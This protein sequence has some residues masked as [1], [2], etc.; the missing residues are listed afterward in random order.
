[1]SVCFDPSGIPVPCTGWT[2]YDS[3]VTDPWYQKYLTIAWTG[4]F[5]VAFVLTLPAIAMAIPRRR[6]LADWLGLLGVYEDATRQGYDPATKR[7]EMGKPQRLT[8]TARKPFIAISALLRA[9]TRL[10]F[11][12]QYSSLSLG[13]VLLALLI[14]TIVLA[15]LLPESQ[16]AE[17]PNR[18]GFLAL[19][20]I[21]PLFVLSSKNGAIGLLLGR[22][23]T[24]VNFLH[25]W[26]GRAV[27]LLVV[28]HFALWTV[29]WS[30]AGELSEF[31]S[32]S[33]ERRGLG[34]FAFLLLITISSLPPFRRFSYPIFFTLHYVSIIGFLVFLNMHTIYARGWATWSVVAIY[35]IDIAGRVASVRVRWVQLEALE[36]GMTRLEMNGVSGG[37]SGG[38]TLD[39]RV[40][41]VPPVSPVEERKARFSR[42][43]VHGYRSLQAAI[44]PFESHPFSIATAPPTRNADPTL[45]DRGIELYMRSCGPGT[46]TEDLYRFATD[47]SSTRSYQPLASDPDPSV[48]TRRSVHALALFFGPYASSIPTYSASRVFAH[49][50][51]VSLFAGGSGMSYVIG[52]L[53]EIIGARLQHDLGG[54]IE[55]TWIVKH[56][57]HASW[58]LSRL[59]SIVSSIPVSHPLEVSVRIHVTSTTNQ[60]QRSTRTTRSPRITISFGRP[61]IS[62]VVKEQIAATLSP[63]RH[64]YPVCKCGDSN[65]TRTCQNEEEECV[66]RCDGIENNSELVIEELAQVPDD[67][68]SGSDQADNFKWDK[69]RAC[70]SKGCC[71]TYPPQVNEVQGPV[72]VRTRGVAFIGCGPLRMTNELRTSVAR[73]PIAHQVRVGGI[74]LYVEQF[75]L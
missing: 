18:F 3:Y 69:G 21:P 60:S 64:C 35:A 61:S 16:L 50:E 30:R 49:T 48:E 9:F 26:I 52:I 41:F 45:R 72:T 54:H 74:D 19:A 36:D 62:Q 68:E 38:Q 7:T 23:W 2:V 53:D 12:R 4:V 39:L 8:L 6:P 65:D 42:W 10:P 55:V 59:E 1:M 14:P 34:A 63:C 22:S 57:S 44:R 70:Y 51:T 31:L 29:Q 28:C 13:H 32:S 25:R 67:T 37:W 47:S 20:C 73:I 24:A 58:F 66:G 11:V 71:S 27:L 43:I 5:A 46:W 75:A 33:K 40:F 56:E 15:T 17:N